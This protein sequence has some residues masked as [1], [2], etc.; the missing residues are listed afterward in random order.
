M[1]GGI[2]NVPIYTI[3]SKCRINVSNGGKCIHIGVKIIFF[4]AWETIINEGFEV[5][6]GV[7]QGPRRFIESV[8][9]NGIAGSNYQNSSTIQQQ[10]IG[11]SMWNRFYSF[12][13]T[14][15]ESMLAGVYW[16]IVDMYLTNNIGSLIFCCMYCCSNAV[17]IN[18]ITFVSVYLFAHVRHRA[19]QVQSPN[20]SSKKESTNR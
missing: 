4:I 11:K 15:S 17:S 5:R 20:T 12:L 19:T 1:L 7:R 14:T 6:E 9:N 16:L 2:L 8:W 10:P 3:G 18:K 13:D